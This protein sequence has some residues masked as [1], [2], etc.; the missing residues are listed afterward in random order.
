MKALIIDRVSSLVA[1]GLKNYGFEVDINILPGR[2]K[3]IKLL[4]SYDLLVMR[5]DPKIDKEVL[6]AAK[7]HIKMIAVCSAGT[8]HIDLTYAKKLGIAVQNAPG[9]NRN[10]VAELTISKML[11]LS[12]M[13]M[14]ANAEV[15]EEGIWDKYKYTGHELK[16]HTLG[17]IGLGKIG[18]RVAELAHA[19]GMKVMAYDPYVPDSDFEQ[20]D[21]QKIGTVNEI[22]SSCDYITVHT[23][24]TDETRNMISEEQFSLMKPTAFV[25]NCARGGI[26]N[27]QAAASYLKQGKIAGIGLDVI[28]NELAGKGLSD[29]AKLSSPLFG[30]K[31]FVVSPHI[32]GS[33]HEA[34]DGIG[35]FIVD[36][37]AQY[38]G[39]KK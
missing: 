25:I 29:H 34:Y 37:V 11:D 33:T 12:R 16:G 1:S 5:V 39:L 27:E 38:Y 3:L 31:G 36:K 35:T 17:I 6:D 14:V 8:N 9:I 24:I 7:G 21:V 22:C 2:D 26:V 10:A 20:Y 30:Q 4:P 28:A 32:G 18:K 13:T 19:F 15:Q 23:P